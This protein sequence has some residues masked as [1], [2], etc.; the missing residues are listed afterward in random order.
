LFLLQ[1]KLVKGL[2]RE[3]DAAAAEVS[4]KLRCYCSAL[5]SR[6]LLYTYQTQLENF[7]ALL[8]ASYRRIDPASQM[9]PARS[10]GKYC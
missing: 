6:Y 3:A 7:G 5:Q 9:L 10:Q 2:E 4:R 8:W 1:H